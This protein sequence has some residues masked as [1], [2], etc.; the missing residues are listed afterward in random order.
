MLSMLPDLLIGVVVVL[1]LSASMS[2]LSSLVLTSSS[3]LTL[4]LLKDNIMKA[5][6]DNAGF[7]RV[8]YCCLSCDRA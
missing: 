2:T 7:N 8:F 6:C 5:D 4:D 1:V 3:T